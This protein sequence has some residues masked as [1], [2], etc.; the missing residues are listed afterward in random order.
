MD[1][2]L[3]KIISRPKNGQNATAADS[4]E[5]LTADRTPIDPQQIQFFDDLNGVAIVVC[6]RLIDLF[7]ILVPRVKMTR[8]IGISSQLALMVVDAPP[9]A[10]V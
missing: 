4:L 9:I 3:S 10:T 8:G 7:G 1:F 2:I 5:H 6:V